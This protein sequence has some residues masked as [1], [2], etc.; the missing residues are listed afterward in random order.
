M[1]IFKPLTFFFFFFLS[2]N[3]AGFLFCNTD[4]NLSEV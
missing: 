4:F 3:G 2:H 1:N